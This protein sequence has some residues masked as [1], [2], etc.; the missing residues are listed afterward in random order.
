MAQQPPDRAA[1]QRELDAWLEE[2]RQAGRQ[3]AMVTSGDLHRRVGWYPPAPGNSLRMRLC[4]EV[5]RSRRGQNDMVVDEP[6]SGQ[7][8]SPKIQYQ[9]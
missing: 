6:P 7:G 2:E 4:C 8:A 3:H 9:L 5:M 1:F